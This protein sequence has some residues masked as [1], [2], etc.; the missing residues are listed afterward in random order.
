MKDHRSQQRKIIASQVTKNTGS[1]PSC[2]LSAAMS[3][4]SL[5]ACAKPISHNEEFENVFAF[6]KKFI[7]Y[8]DTDARFENAI[9]HTKNFLMERRYN[10]NDFSFSASNHNILCEDDRIAVIVSSDTQ[11]EDVGSFLGWTNEATESHR[12]RF[13]YKNVLI[14]DL[15][16]IN[17]LHYFAVCDG[18]KQSIS[19]HRV[20]R[21][22]INMNNVSKET[23]ALA[24]SRVNQDLANK[25]IDNLHSD[26][27]APK[28]P[29]HAFKKA[30]VRTK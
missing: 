7:V 17:T 25:T 2:E 16:S 26:D 24:L 27:S 19:N 8:D 29:K 3:K 12:Q 1:L 9:N 18:D 21:R 4:A 5:S 13:I 20:N 22:I 10:I 14:D 30:H 11:I 23:Q 15:K 28:Q 6:K